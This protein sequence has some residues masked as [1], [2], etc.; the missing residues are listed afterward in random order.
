MNF[1]SFIALI[2]FFCTLGCSRPAYFVFVNNTGLPLEITA[3]GFVEAI[4][5]GSFGR[6]RFPGNSMSLS[7][8]VSSDRTWTYSVAYPPAGYIHDDTI[9]AQIEANGFI[10][11]FPNE[12]STITTNLPQQPSGFPLK[13]INPS[14]AVETN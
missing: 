1:R 11:V 10:H 4:P 5:S 12:I 14:S 6:V 13:S 7:I 2:M 3:D 8:K 9:Y